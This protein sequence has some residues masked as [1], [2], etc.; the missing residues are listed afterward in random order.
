[1]GSGDYGVEVV[2]I[3]AELHVHTVLSPCAEIEM[4]PPLVVAE[5]IER[6]LGMI[7]ITDHNSTANIRSVIKAAEGS[8]L[9]IFP[10]MELQ[11]REEVH[12]LC[13]FDKMEQVDQLQALVDRH[14]P[15]MKNKPDF[16]G[17]QFIVDETGD[18]IKRED[19]LLIT[20][21]DI[22]FEESV[23]EVHNL[24]GLAI[25]AHVNRKAYGLFA[26]LGFIPQGLKV[27]A[28][29]LSRHLSMAD[30]QKFYPQV[31]GYPLLIGGDAHRL[32]EILGINEFNIQ[33]RNIAEIK[34]AL[35]GLDGRSV[36]II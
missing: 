23:K 8:D 21:V 35:M 6:G 34:M 22:S 7:A 16:F 30:A 4:I 32:D 2:K 26:N 36:E 29:E 15:E 31:S 1:V 10:G 3:R 25:P 14:Y 5:S 19:R 17:E 20:S 24:G 13:L 18:F 12:L 27:D 11:T 28:L 33:H 9:R